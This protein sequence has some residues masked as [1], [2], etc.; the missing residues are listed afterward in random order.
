MLG[1]A[2]R[3]VERCGTLQ[4]TGKIAD[5]RKSQVLPGNV[6]DQG[7]FKDREPKHTQVHIGSSDREPG[8]H[9]REKAR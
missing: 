4:R 2:L 6:E 5:L 7:E 1:E 8:G 9:P 3:R